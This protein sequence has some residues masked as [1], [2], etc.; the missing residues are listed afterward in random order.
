MDYE[1]IMNEILKENNITIDINYVSKS[2]VDWNTERNLHNYYI[3]TLERNDK[4]MQYDFYA[5]VKN[6]RE[7][8]KPTNYDVMACL[9][10]YELGTF[11]DFCFNFGYNEDSI[12]ALNTYLKCQ[13]QQ[14]ELFSIIPEKKIREKIR[15]II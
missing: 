11:Q 8:K 12:K 2:L 5:S 15:E 3:V 14:E 13:K 9:E 7:N 4:K 1:K 10:W 6:T